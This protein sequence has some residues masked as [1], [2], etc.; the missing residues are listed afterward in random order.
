MVAERLLQVLTR[1]GETPTLA[2]HLVTVLCSLAVG[3]LT[4][5]WNSQRS[6]G[7]RTLAASPN[8]DPAN[9]PSLLWPSGS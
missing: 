2:N 9:Y 3:G 7:V 8:S 6:S 4:I 5:R 1:W